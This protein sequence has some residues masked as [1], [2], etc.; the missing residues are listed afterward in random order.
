MHRKDLTKEMILR[1][2]RNTKSNRAAARYLHVSYPHYKKW[3]KLFDSDERLDPNDPNSPFKSCFE[4]HENRSGRG[5]AKFMGGAINA[6]RY[7]IRDIIEGRISCDSF[8]PNMIKDAMIKEGLLRECCDMCDYKERRE[9]DFKMP[10]LLHFRDGNRRNYD[11]ENCRLVCYN[12]YFIHVTDIF[13]SKQEL[14]IQDHKAL[15]RKINDVDWE[16]DEF[17]KAKLDEITNSINSPNPKKDNDD[18]DENSLISRL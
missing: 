11:P 16:L 18:F 14:A 3:A 5:I 13:T 4:K 2:M 8:P 1:A 17:Q 12:C 9:S 6:D 7:P 15:T 10:L